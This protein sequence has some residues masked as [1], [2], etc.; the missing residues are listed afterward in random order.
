MVLDRLWYRIVQTVLVVA[1]HRPGK[2]QD[3]ALFIIGESQ[4]ER[5]S[6]ICL[7]R[8]QYRC[9]SMRFLII[10]EVD[11]CISSLSLFKFDL[12]CI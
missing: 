6:I 3:R 9:G 12:L 4:A 7:S 5:N 11:F 10:Q 8:D 1:V 2:L